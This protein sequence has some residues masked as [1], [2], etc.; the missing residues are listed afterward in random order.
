MRTALLTLT[1]CT[2][3]TFSAQSQTEELFRCNYY[4]KKLDETSICGMLGFRSRP[5]AIEAVNEIVRRSGL[6][7]N[8]YVMECPNID[9]CFAAV[10]DGERLI[11]YDAAFMKKINGMT[12][13]DWSAMSIL[14]HE[15]GHHLQGH[16]LKMGGSEQSKEIEADEFSG[17]VMYQMGAT[18]KE[19]QSAIQ[20]LATDY[21]SG[22]HPPK[23]QRL[24]AI[25][26]GFD[27]AKALYPSVQQ[28]QDYEEQPDVVAET[29]PTK[30]EKVENKTVIM[31]NRTNAKTGCITG[32]C[33]FGYGV[34]VNRYT[35][36]KYAG[37]WNDGRREGVGIEFYNNGNKKFEGEFVNSKYNGKG[38]YYFVNGDIFEG[39]FENG[40]MNGELNVYYYKNGD[41]LFV[42]YVEGKKQGKAKIIFSDG[43]ISHVYFRDDK[44]LKR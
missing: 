4:G 33:R 26:R 40:E 37:G 29:T 30:L 36:E 14:A 39:Y 41:R 28:K 22:T 43:T 23:G 9:N 20:R 12:N 5:E 11:V 3:L 13:T 34:A 16:T 44:E 32:D 38:R 35:L 18:L 17:F 15:I 19:A 31:D 27:N 21:D 24:G 1:I 10:R 6:K 7:Q 25:K 42:K 8:F 2:L